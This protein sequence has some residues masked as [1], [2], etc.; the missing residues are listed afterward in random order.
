[1][2]NR[3]TVGEAVFVRDMTT[4]APPADTDPIPG[5]AATSASQDSTTGPFSK[6]LPPGAVA[7]TAGSGA[8]AQTIGDEGRTA[9]DARPDPLIPGQR[10]AFAGPNAPPQVIVPPMP[11]RVM[12]PP[13][14]APMPGPGAPPIGTEPHDPGAPNSTTPTGPNVIYTDEPGPYMS[15]PGTTVVGPSF[16]RQHQPLNN[17]VYGP[18]YYTNL[19]PP[20]NYVQPLQ[21]GWFQLGDGRLVRQEEVEKLYWE[22]LRKRKKE[23]QQREADRQGSEGEQAL[24][25]M[26]GQNVRISQVPTEKD[27]EDC[28]IRPHSINQGK[29]SA[30]GKASHHGMIDFPFRTGTQEQTIAGQ[31]FRA[32]GAPS[33][34]GAYTI[35]LAGGM[36]SPHSRLHTRLNAAIYK[37]GTNDIT[38]FEEVKRLSFI[39]IDKLR[40]EVLSPHCKELYK[41]VLTNQYRCEDN[42]NLRAR[43]YSPL[44]DKD[45]D[46]GKALSKA[47]RFTW[48]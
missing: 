30:I 48:P 11:P 20:L 17:P 19:P 25:G 1:M 22:Q 45:N 13:L 15:A 41:L 29:C 3:N 28:G 34:M 7:M 27:K 4:H 44:P 6:A 37:S 36:A 23:Q 42:L 47:W 18:A 33:Y 46:V 16:F 9:T 43:P 39:E 32:P 21:G 40:S 35:C 10:Y 8:W 38:D 12:V 26:S 31:D 5:S 2:N 14:P 24:P